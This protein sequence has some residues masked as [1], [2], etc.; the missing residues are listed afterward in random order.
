MSK[1]YNVAIYIRLSREDGDDME[2]ESIKNQRSILTK[3]V[4]EIPEFNLVDEYVDENYTG[5]NF[6]RP[7]FKRL[8]ADIEKNKI[9]TVITKDISRF[10]RENIWT[11]YYHEIYFPEKKIRY[12]SILDRVDTF[13]ENNIANEIMPFNRIVNEW[14]SKDISKKIRSSVRSKKEDGKF[15]GWK[16]VYGYIKDP[17]DKNKLLVD[18]EAAIVVRRMFELAKRGKSPRQIA[19]IFS[20]EKIP[21]PSN[22][23]NLNRGNKST[24][25]NLWTS[26][27]IDE[28]L[29]KETYIGNLTQ[30]TRKKLSYKSKKEVRTP[31]SEWI[32]SKNTHEPI[33]DEETFYIVQELLQKNKNNP[34]GK[35]NHLLRGL[36]KCK[37]CGHS[38]GINFSSDKKRRYCVCSYYTAYSKFN[39]CTPHSMN[40]DKLEQAVLDDIKNIC[41]IYV[42]DTNFENQVEEAKKKNDRKEKLKKDIRSMDK[43]IEKTTLNLDKL[44]MDNLNEVITIEM[45]NRMS[46]K[47][48][49]EIDNLKLKKIESN[50]LLNNIDSNDSKKE[51]E[52]TLEKIKEFLSFEKPPREMIV[53]LIDKIIIDENKN[54]EIFY[55]FRIK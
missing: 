23:A 42:S 7:A 4:N 27:T 34:Q 24:A 20:T 48:S 30:G 31:K 1:T 36:L 35:N 18:E 43:K 37:D 2:S 33:I 39:L 10:G 51:K 47:L 12:I 41:S 38:I 25:Y 3:Y 6:D 46:L 32:I 53:N 26:R 54:V 55:N 9:D 29:Q 16:A 40:Y 11:G 22:Y 15:L 44:Y 14:Y 5:M 19:N 17:L 21:T 49:E 50:S 8:I 13:D 45:Y 52:E 28:M